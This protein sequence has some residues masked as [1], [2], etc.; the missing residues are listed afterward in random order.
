MNPL[1]AEWRKSMRSA[2]DNCVEV[3]YQTDQATVLVRDTKA[4]GKGPVLSFTRGEW[5][6]FLAGVQDGEFNLPA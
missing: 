3:S 6:A 4:D 5:T 1:G 2:Q